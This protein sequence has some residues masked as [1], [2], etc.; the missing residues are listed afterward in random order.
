MPLLDVSALSTVA[1]HCVLYHI[2]TSDGGENKDVYVASGA[3]PFTELLSLVS[4][5]NNA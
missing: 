3:H 4:K 5:H 2:F 1:T